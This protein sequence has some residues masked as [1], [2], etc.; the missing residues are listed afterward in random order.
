MEVLWT[1]SQLLWQFHYNSSRGY[2]IIFISLFPLWKFYTQILVF[3]VNWPLFLLYLF[4]NTHLIM[5]RN[6]TH[7]LL[8]VP[9]FRFVDLKWLLFK[10]YHDFQVF[11]LLHYFIFKDLYQLWYFLQ[12]FKIFVEK[13]LLLTILISFIYLNLNLIIPN[14]T[15]YL[16]TILK[17]NILIEKNVKYWN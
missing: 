10:K 4:S 16:N 1:S 5:F 9:R 14:W 12:I 11:V 13:I 8:H 7:Y 6:D 15:K 17:I 2:F 3:W